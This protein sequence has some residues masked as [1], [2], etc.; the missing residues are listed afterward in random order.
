MSSLNPGGGG[1]RVDADYL[2]D[3]IRP[4][5]DALQVADRIWKDDGQMAAGIER[6][7]SKAITINV[8]RF[9]HDWGHAMGL[10]VKQGTAV[11]YALERVVGAYRLAEAEARGQFTPAGAPQ[12][13]VPNGQQPPA[14][15]PPAG[16]PPT[17]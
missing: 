11:A 3:T 7:G 15:A 10:V 5:L 2:T 1:F 8:Q 14:G 17:R 16:A 12:G 13:A 9:V 6:C 4:I